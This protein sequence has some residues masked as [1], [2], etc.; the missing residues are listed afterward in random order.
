MNNYIYGDPTPIREMLSGPFT[1]I[2]IGDSITDRQQLQWMS[3]FP[4]GV[5]FGG[6]IMPGAVSIGQDNGGS[7]AAGAFG[8]TS[9][10]GS[11]NYSLFQ[12]MEKTFLDS[13]RLK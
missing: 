8:T 7:H 6:F 4:G 3:M 12:A 5:P 11:G 13:L 10:L 1:L 2:D 9:L